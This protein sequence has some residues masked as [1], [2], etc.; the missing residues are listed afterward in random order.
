MNQFIFKSR[1]I[2][3]AFTVLTLFSA[4][5]LVGGDGDGS[6]LGNMQGAVIEQH[7]E[8]TQQLAMVGTE[9]PPPPGATEEVMMDDA[10]YVDDA[11]LI[12]TASGTD[13]APEGEDGGFA[14]D[15]GDGPQFIPQNDSDDTGDFDNGDS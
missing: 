6:V 14:D 13:P 8:T 5:M 12:D 1:W 9:A 2:A 4:Y 15:G 10:E 11:E 3:I 7:D